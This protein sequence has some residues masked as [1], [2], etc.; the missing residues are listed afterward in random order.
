MAYAL[1]GDVTIREP[2][3]KIPGILAHRGKKH[4]T[5]EVVDWDTPASYRFRVRS[6]CS[7]S[8]ASLRVPAGAV[9]R[10]CVS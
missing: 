4:T 10:N 5:V 2:N 7:G 3:G 8:S 1:F 6:V 9:M